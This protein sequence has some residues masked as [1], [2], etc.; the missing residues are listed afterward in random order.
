MHDSLS[1]PCGRQ[2]LSRRALLAAAGAALAAPP[3]CAGSADL[4]FRHVW[5][6]ITLA[7]PARRVVS[8]GANTQ[9]ALLALGVAPVAI[10][11]WYGDYPFGVWPWAQD[12]LG[13]AAPVL[14]R[15]E[16]SAETIAGLRPDLILG[17]ASGI[18]QEE[19]ALLSRIAPVLM[20]E[21]QYST[22]GTPWQAM[23]RTIGRAVGRAA[24]AERLVRAVEAE[25]AAF[26]ARHPDWVGR[27]AVA[28]WQDAGQTG[29]FTA[30]D[31]R[32]RFLTEL[33]FRQP[34]ALLA[35]TALDGFWTTVSSEDFAPLDAD[36]LIWISD[37]ARV[38]D[39]AALPMRR[40]MRAWREGREIFSD[41]ITTGAM[42]FGT[43]LSLPFALRALEPEMMLALDGDPGTAVP[44]ARRAGLAP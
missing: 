9:D 19:H 37:E 10:R 23:T 17:M 35:R 7:A 14:L 30:E 5:G 13:D 25:F 26:R 44:S 11:S 33:G 3:L 34:E 18:S 12:A 1:R 22:W 40:T 4:H 28:A 29:A 38:P 20:Q 39:I 6:E 43:V 24:Q 2:A 42:S 8:L 31:T 32:A 27:T 16:A 15:G 41:R 36:L 21:P